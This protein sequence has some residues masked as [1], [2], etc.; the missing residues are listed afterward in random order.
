M[1]KYTDKIYDK[2][3]VNE[4]LDTCNILIDNECCF[5]DKKEI[6]ISEE[7]SNNHNE[8]AEDEDGE[9]YYVDLLKSLIGYKVKLKIKGDHKHDG[10]LVEYNFKFTSPEGVKT[11][12]S[13]DM[14]LM[15]GF[16]YHEEI[17]IG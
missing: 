1:E 7:Y 8:G 5:K 2:D 13:T 14:C 11:L 10:Q 15:M 17:T 16:N 12:I 9:E 4:L 3:E 6:I